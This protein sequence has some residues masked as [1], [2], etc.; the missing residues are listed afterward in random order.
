MWIGRDG[1]FAGSS[2]ATAD[3]VANA[4]NPAHMLAEK[5]LRGPS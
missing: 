5:Y 3:N 1:Y 2:C 4:M